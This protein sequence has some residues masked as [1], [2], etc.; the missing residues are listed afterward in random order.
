LVEEDL[1]SGSVESATKVVQV[2]EHNLL[3]IEREFAAST[4]GN[5]AFQIQ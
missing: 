1:L 2:R 3:A 5:F 4:A